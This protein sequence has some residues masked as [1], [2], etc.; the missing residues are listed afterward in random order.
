MSSHATLQSPRCDA[1]WGDSLYALER[2]VLAVDVCAEM[3]GTE[4]EGT[5]SAT[6]LTRLSVVVDALCVLVHA[7]LEANSAH[8]F[9][10]CIVGD[11][12]YVRWALDFTN[13]ASAVCRALRALRPQEDYR[14]FDLAELFSRVQERCAV[15]L[16]DATAP[17]RTVR[18]L[19]TFGRR[20]V[21]PWHRGILSFADIF[22]TAI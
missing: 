10:V 14:R 20:L 16:T 3:A 2:I 8:Q 12:G 4:F 21:F 6:P 19:L 22:S 11:V 15:E 9:A 13:D 18:V 17:A 5:Q 7:K 1:L